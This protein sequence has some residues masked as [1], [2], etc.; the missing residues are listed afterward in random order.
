M[1]LYTGIGDKGRTQLFGG[2]EVPKDHL[3][4]E[5]YG[6]VDELNSALGL[7]AAACDHDDLRGLLIELQSRCFDLGA[8][9]ATPR[10]GKASGMA[11]K[12]KRVE[13]DWVTEVERRI[14]AI[15]DGLPPIKHFILPGGTEL[16]ARLHLART[17]CRRAERRL[18]ALKE[19]ENVGE[20]IPVYLNRVSD[21]LFACARWANQLEGVA[22]VEWV[23]KR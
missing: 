16:A 22:D 14:D 4:V 9:L 19:V 12:V 20:A 10:E 18:V 15:S 17:S 2:Q 5:A 6:S 23:A 13:Q 1:K 3:R 11:G 21:L 7:A 8:D